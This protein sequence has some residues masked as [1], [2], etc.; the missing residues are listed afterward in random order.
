MCRK[1]LKSNVMATMRRL[2]HSRADAREISILYM[3][4]SDKVADPM[5]EHYDFSDE[6]LQEE[7]ELKRQAFTAHENSILGQVFAVLLT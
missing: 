4:H 5:G 2:G 6:I 3:H 7:M 1:F